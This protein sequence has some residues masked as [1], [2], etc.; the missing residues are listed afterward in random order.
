MAKKILT[1]IA[2]LCALT[3]SVVFGQ[4]SLGR[5]LESKGFV[6][7]SPDRE[8]R[9]RLA[10]LSQEASKEWEKFTGEKLTAASPIIIV[11]KTRAAKPRGSKGAQCNL[12]E[13]DEGG[14]KVQIDVFDNW[15]MRPG[16]FETE[17]I[18]AL[19]LRAMHRQAPPKVGKT[20]TQPPGWLVEGIGEQIR[21][22]S[23]TVPDGVHAAL[24]Q[25]ER[26]PSLG[27]F[28]QQKTERLD[29]TSLLLFRA[30]ALALVKAISESKNSKKQFLAYLES[31]ACTSSDPAKL[32]EAFPD[33]SPDLS[34]LTKVWTL[35]LARSSMPPRLA[36]LTVLKTDEE[37]GQILDLEVPADPKK[38]NSTG[39]SGP[40]ALPLAAR[41]PGGA[42][43]MRQRLVDLLNLEFRAHPLLRPIVEEYRNIAMLLAAKP[44][45]KVEHRIEEVEKIRALL[46]ERHKAIA[47]YLNWFEAT[48]INESESPLSETTRPDPVPPRRDPITL[49]M[50]AIERRGW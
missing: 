4:Q 40:M 17:V 45:S 5:S 37:L 7:Y 30:Q 3:A 38:K 15:A 10:R 11:D 23:R 33:A 26:P 2:V 6:I 44:K 41:N 34:S 18:R 27:D 36:S 8:V 32:L 22:S 28:M 21:R 19:A 49:Y 12:F 48:Q 39:A 47:D 1:L 13:M 16:Y 50:D 43:L 24:I 20:Y 9:S 31:P 46:V 35:A 29:V 14:M 42:F 25:S